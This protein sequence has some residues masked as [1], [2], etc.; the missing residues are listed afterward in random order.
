MEAEFWHERWRLKQIGFHLDRPNPRLL[1]HHS[2]LA[3][4]QRVLVPLCGKSLDLPWL[5]EQGH[6]VVGVELSDLAVRELFE[7]CGL[8]PEIAQHG[9]FTRYRA[10]RIEVL[11]GDVFALN[12]ETLGRVDAL[13]DRAA[14]VALPESMRERYVQLMGGLVPGGAKGLLVSFE[15]EPSESAGPPFSIEEAR[16]R[17]LYEGQFDVQLLEREDILDREPRFRERGL[18]ALREC[19]YRLT[20]R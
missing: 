8:T 20:R 10:G 2:V 12:Q 11:C 15:Y 18:R 6:H 16:V 3:S 1:A 14:L 19:S 9:P 4:Q 5:V 13:Y 7:H 17:A